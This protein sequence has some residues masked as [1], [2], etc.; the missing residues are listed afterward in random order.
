VCCASPRGG[1]PPAVRGLPRGQACG[2]G[3]CTNNRPGRTR[4]PTRPRR[5]NQKP[6]CTF[7]IFVAETRIRLVQLVI[8]PGALERRSAHEIQLA[9]KRHATG[10]WGEVPEEDE[11]ENQRALAQGGRLFSAY[12]SED[13]QTRFYVITEADRSVTTVLLPEEY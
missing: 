4:G 5:M 12:R 7:T 8:T 1:P 11:P 2:V 13:G 6:P 9:L 3:P 10:D